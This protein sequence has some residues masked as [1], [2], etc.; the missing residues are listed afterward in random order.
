VGYLEREVVKVEEVVEEAVVEEKSFEFLD[1][2]SQE[3]LI[4]LELENGDRHVTRSP[5]RRF[6]SV[7]FKATLW[8]PA[9]W[10]NVSPARPSTASTFPSRII[11][12]KETSFWVFST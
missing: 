5:K 12:V 6:E 8:T 4:N 9:K 3:E 1:G 2:L 10:P 7:P 11:S